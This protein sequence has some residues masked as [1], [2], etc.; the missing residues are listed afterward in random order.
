ME[1]IQRNAQFDLAASFV[2][3]TAKNVY[4]TGRAGTGKTTFL[5]Y[6][7]EHT[8]KKI[9]IAAPT[10]VAAMNAGGVTLH[11]LFQLPFGSF[12]PVPQPAFSASPASGTDLQT[13]LR[14]V[15][16]SSDKRKL[17][18]ELE[19]LVI[20]EVSMVRADMLDAADQVLRHFRKNGKPFGGVQ[21]LLIGDMNQL[22]PVVKD[23][24]WTMLSSYYKSMFF[25][26]A[27]VLKENQ[28]ACIELQTIYRQTDTKFINLLN[29]IRNNIATD[30]DLDLL[31]RHYDPSF[32]PE[33]DDGYIILTSHNYKADKIN[34]SNLSRLPSNVYEFEGVLQGDFNENALPVSRKLCLKEGAQVMFIKN[35]KGENR[36]FYNG[37]IGIISRLRKDEI[38]VRFPGEPGEM[39]VEQETWRNIRYQYNE[40]DDSI[41]EEALGSYQQYPL[42]LAWAVTI[43][44]S[45]GLTFEKAIIDAAQSFAP[46][47]VYVALSRLTSLGGLVLSSPISPQAIFT[48]SR[49]DTFN[50]T[51]QDD[52]TLQEILSEAQQEYLEDRLTSSFSFSKLTDLFQAQHYSYKEMK[53]PNMPDA[54]QWSQKSL[55]ALS[56]INETGLKFQN[57]L[58]RLLNGGHQHL[59]GRAIAARNYFK[60][61]IETTL[62]QPLDVHIKDSEAKKGTKKYGG[63][64]RSLRAA[65]LQKLT[66]MDSIVAITESLSRGEGISEAMQKGN[67]APKAKI[68]ELPEAKAGKKEDTKLISLRMMQEGKSLAE[69][70]VARGYVTSTIASHLVHFIP[71]GEVR[72][73]HLMTAETE[74]IIRR[75]ISK[76]GAQEIAEVK[77][78]LDDSIQYYEIKAVLAQLQKEQTA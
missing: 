72:L 28:P 62:L 38:W 43:H 51:H 12:I 4:L 19:L 32:Y 24:D 20:D 23:D 26:D 10:G 63:M 54:L 74:Q 55:L 60:N 58:Q 48:E 41:A 9:A 45:Q 36:R 46:G 66:E 11:S 14:S 57:E 27:L 15:R 68:A 16:F 64:L 21:V 31:N 69:I 2:L 8:K 71:T 50:N 33:G 34:E 73:L 67:E 47:Q 39:E 22:P 37:K 42:R 77:Q 35:D 75:H 44:K 65:L 7:R 1:N 25:F 56:K 18:R 49:I 6:I 78:A 61:E 5:K 13:M 30:E 17:M 40:K 52:E 29:A 3:H 53:L 76:Y 59:S 70:A